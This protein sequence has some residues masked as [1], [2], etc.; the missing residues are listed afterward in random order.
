MKKII[1]LLLS[2]LLF[3]SCTTKQE[4]EINNQKDSQKTI[5]T[6]WDSLT[7]W[8]NLALENSYPS[9]LESILNQNNYNYKIINAGVSWDTSKDLLNRIELYDDTKA[10]IY[11]LCIWWNDWL[12]KLDLDSM[13][14]NIISII[15]Y[16]QKQNPDAKIVLF[17][18]E[19]PINL[20][21]NYSSNFKKI[22]K[23]I[24]DEKDTYFYKS[25]LEWVAKDVKLN[26]NDWIHPNKEWYTII[27][28]NIFEFLKEEGIIK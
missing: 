4:T 24:A 20:W 21:L 14:E 26:Q 17:W 10:D 25:F 3:T 1:F 2:V 13:K 18:M 23:Q 6:L 11:L 5:I 8:Y 9:Q 7:A 28:N 19:I 22:F 16:I 15:D 12:R 27:A